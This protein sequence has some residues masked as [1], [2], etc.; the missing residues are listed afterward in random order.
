M[1]MLDVMNPMD[2]RELN[3]VDFE[4]SRIPL[5]MV[6][7]KYNTPVR[8]SNLQLLLIPDIEPHYIPSAGHPFTSQTVNLFQKFVDSGMLKLDRS[9][10]SGKRVHQNIKNTEIGVQWY[11]NLIGFEYSLNYFYHWSDAPLFYPSKNHVTD[12]INYDLKY[13]R[14]HTLG[15]KFTNQFSKFLGIKDV[16]MRGEMAVHLED[17]I[18]C[19]YAKIGDDPNNIFGTK[20]SKTDTVNYLI[21]FDKFLFSDYF[22]SIQ[23]YQFITLDW[24]KG[25]INMPNMYDVDWADG[26]ILSSKIDRV[27]TLLTFYMSTDFYGERL[28]PDFLIVYADDGAFWFRGRSRFKFS[29]TRSFCIGTNQYYGNRNTML[30]Q[31]KDVDNIF[32]ELKFDF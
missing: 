8:G 32:C 22:T 16:I 23:F 7:L 1:K 6:N 30:G 17:R 29:D 11:H 10:T 2:V 19:R 18:P 5:W 26:E 3:Q 14:Y 21:G 20:M 27:E 28:C 4:D 9:A 13:H 24:E 12:R 31:F 15:G 25:Y